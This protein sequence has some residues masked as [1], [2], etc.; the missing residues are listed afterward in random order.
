MQNKANFPV[1]QTNVSAVIT[2]GCE[3]LTMNNEP[4]KQTQTKPFSAFNNN[5]CCH[6]N[7]FAISRFGIDQ[8][9]QIA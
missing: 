1:I 2:K 5:T 6:H 3:H 4:K 8:R 7:F 9:L